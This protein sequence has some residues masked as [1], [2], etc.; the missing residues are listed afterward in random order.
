M[1]KIVATIFLVSILA[2]LFLPLASYAEESYDIKF[3]KFQDANGNLEYDSGDT[4]ISGN[5]P[6]VAGNCIPPKKAEYSGFVLCGKC[7]GITDANDVA[8][9]TIRGTLTPKTKQRAEERCGGVENQIYV[10]CQLCHFFTTITQVV[11]FVLGTIVPPIAVLMLV[12]GG[13]MFYLGGAKPD[14]IQRGRKLIVSVAIGLAL[15]YGAYMIV[16]FL[17]TVVGAANIG[18]I[19]S[20]FKNGLFSIDC[21]IVIPIP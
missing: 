5:D 17:L 18:A 16:G 13:A 6:S 9:N 19:G 7:V 10:D 14:M 8:D 2:G 15:I 1:P 4:W 20:V 12:I 21:P 11:G 3:C